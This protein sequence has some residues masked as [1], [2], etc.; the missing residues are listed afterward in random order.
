VTR[1]ARSRGGKHEF[2][3]QIFEFKINIFINNNMKLGNI[4]I[5][6]PRPSDILTPEEVAQYLKVSVSWVYKNQDLLGGRKL[7]GSLRFPGKDDLYEYLFRSRQRMEV[8]FP[9]Q[10][11]EV[12]K[13]LLQD[14]D[15]G[16]SSGGRKKEGT[17]ES[18]PGSKDP[19][20][21][22]LLDIDE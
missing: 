15:R 10:E 2:N 8:R 12:S 9:I 4:N 19:N 20:R 21:H 16:K 3:L 13:Q 17:E 5:D 18:S 14:Q 7:R 22:G 1:N 11:K 6:K